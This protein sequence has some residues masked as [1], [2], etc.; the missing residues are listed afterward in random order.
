MSGYLANLV[1]RTFQREATPQPI[2]AP[3]FA[4]APAEPAWMSESVWTDEHLAGDQARQVR[5]DNR[6]PQIEFPTVAQPFASRTEPEDSHAVVSQ[7]AR[8]QGAPHDSHASKSSSI[9]GPQRSPIQHDTKV[10]AP[11]HGPIARPAIPSLLAKFEPA[12]RHH[13]PETQQSVQHNESRLNTAYVPSSPNKIAPN[14]SEPDPSQSSPEG[15]ISHQVTRGGPADRAR[16]GENARDGKKVTNDFRATG[17]RKATS[18]MSA[19]A[20]TQPE[21]LAVEKHLFHAPRIPDKDSRNSPFAPNQEPD[22]NRD[23]PSAAPVAS[24]ARELADEAYPGDRTQRPVPLPAAPSQKLPD[25][26]NRVLG[27]QQPASPAEPTIEV[28]IGRIEVRA[29]TQGD[30]R[31]REPA[32]AILPSLADYLRKRSGQDRNE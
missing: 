26:Q 4:P 7:P 31:Q 6:P 28:T 5:N 16:H 2:L 25:S 19:F 29:A 21:D 15:Q 18:A 17:A 8:N 20:S 9:P 27:Y 1:S 3:L 10:S 12:D 30:R 24:Q 13:Q 32:P 22:A 11:A 14:L 23:R